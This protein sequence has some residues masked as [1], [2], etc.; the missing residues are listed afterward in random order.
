VGDGHDHFLLLDEVLDRE[1]PRLP[2]D[3]RAP[4]VGEEL[5]DLLQL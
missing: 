5:P 2:L 1:L 3:L 4:L